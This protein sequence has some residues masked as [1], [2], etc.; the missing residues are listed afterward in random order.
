VVASSASQRGISMLQT[1]P[2]LRQSPKLDKPENP[3][4]R[5]R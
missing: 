5:G 4:T 1:T 3:D 2:F